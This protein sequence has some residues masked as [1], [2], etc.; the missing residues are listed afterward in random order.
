MPRGGRSRRW[1][2]PC[3]ATARRCRCA[4]ASAWT[5][6]RP[7]A[8]AAAAAGIGAGAGIRA[9]VQ[10]LRRAPDPQR[11]LRGRQRRRGRAGTLSLCLSYRT[12]WST[13]SA[14]RRA[15][16][17]SPCRRCAWP[18]RSSCVPSTRRSRRRGAGGCSG[19]RRLGKRIVL[20]LGGRPLPRA[21]PDD[22]RAPALEG[23]PA[24]SRPGRIGLAAF[25]FPTGS[26]LSPRR[27]RSAG[28]G[29]AWSPA[30]RRCAPSTPAGWKCSRPPRRLPPPPSA[31]RTTPSSAR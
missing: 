5:T 3:C 16:R 23:R 29:C 30:R 8:T 2:R 6:H 24:A 11:A 18:T 7:S 10:P 25:D 17:G 31:P 9:E 28:P 1:T 12:S 14:W 21:A 26:L 20:A 15:C 22:R 19:V 4:C 27:G 13:S